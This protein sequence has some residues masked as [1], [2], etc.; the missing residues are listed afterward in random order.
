[1]TGRQAQMPSAPAE[2]DKPSRKSLRSLIEPRDITLVGELLMLAFMSW[3]LPQRSWNPLSNGLALVRQLF[4]RD[5]A[6]RVNHVNALLQGRDLSRSLGHVL[7]SHDANNYLERLQLLRIH[8]PGGWNPRIHLEGGNNIETG[9][10]AKYGVIL[11]VSALS[12][13]R[14]G[15]KMALYEAGYQVSHLSRYSHGFQS[16]SRFAEQFLNPIRTTAERQYVRERIVIGRSGSKGVL[17]LLA[18]RLKRNEIVSITVGD[19][20]RRVSTVPFL[21]GVLRLASGPIY[22]SYITK[23]PLLP[24]FTIRESGGGFITRVEPP[25]SID[26]KANADQAIHHAMTDYVT[27]LEAYALRYPDQFRW[28]KVQLSDPEF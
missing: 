7:S 18:K 8:R 23:A 6:P 3:L 16:K 24:V 26:R 1:M 14:Q 19:E 20:A 5:L 21:N 28:H 15:T 10:Q 9:L 12:F 25:L 22:L 2:P 27:L 17:D 4:R 13:H 11:W